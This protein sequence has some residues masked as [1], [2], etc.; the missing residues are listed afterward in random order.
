M[1]APYD[2]NGMKQECYYTN[3]A[4]VLIRRFIHISLNI[5]KF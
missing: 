2:P 4:A 1:K 5:I 3:H